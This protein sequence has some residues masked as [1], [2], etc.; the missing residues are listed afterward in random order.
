MRVGNMER[1]TRKN[2]KWNGLVADL[3]LGREAVVIQL[4]GGTRAK[5][6][7]SEKCRAQHQSVGN[8]DAGRVDAPETSVN[9]E[10]GARRLSITQGLLFPSGFQVTDKGGGING[11]V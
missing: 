9:C 1:A 5:C 8:Q 11:T 3:K 4:L 10:S 2:R 6:M 7:A